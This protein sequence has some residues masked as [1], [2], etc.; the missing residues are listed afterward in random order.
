MDQSSNFAIDILYI[1]ASLIVWTNIKGHLHRRRS[2]NWQIY[3]HDTTCE[4]KPFMQ[5]RISLSHRIMRV[6]KAGIDV[7]NNQK[8]NQNI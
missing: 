8:G 1:T 7:T 2:P 6:I 3:C 5:T 4:C